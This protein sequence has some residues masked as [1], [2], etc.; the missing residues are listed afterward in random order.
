[1]NS[2]SPRLKAL[3][4]ALLA[5]LVAVTASQA[6]EVKEDHFKALLEQDT[7]HLTKS[8]KDGTPDKK[9]IIQSKATALMI[10]QAAQ[11]R[12]TGSDKS[13]DAQMATLRDNAVKVAEAVA[14]KKY[15]DAAEIAKLL[16]LKTPADKSAKTD[17]IEVHKKAKFDMIDLMSPLKK[18]TSG[19]LNVENDIKDGSEKLKDVSKVP[20]LAARIIVLAELTEKM[21]TDT[22][23]GKKSEANWKK[24]AKM[25]KDAATETYE[26]ST[27]AKPDVKKVQA[28]LGKI[29]A[30]C[31]ECHNV[32]K[33]GG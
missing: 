4:A 18:T 11:D 12:I 6:I 19:G 25:M 21:P 28:A 9:G 15:K 13:A 10:A 29:N 16:S 14:A 26:V 33:T 24:Y 8:L 17:A 1:M 3:G 23:A 22:G 31:T 30:S 27:V 7:N 20:V 2:R 5:S 32:F